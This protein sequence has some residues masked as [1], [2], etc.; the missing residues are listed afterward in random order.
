[1]KIPNFFLKI[2]DFFPLQHWLQECCKSPIM[3]KGTL[4]VLVDQIHHGN[5]KAASHFDIQPD[6][7]FLSFLFSPSS[8]VS[9]KLLDGAA[10]PEKSIFSCPTVDWLPAER[11]I[12]GRQG[13][14]SLMLCGRWHR[15]AALPS[16]PMALFKISAPRLAAVCG[17]L[18]PR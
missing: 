1:M 18:C 9:L 3:H 4:L 13:A 2:K 5:Q 12:V 10:P 15:L 14:E 6:A 8:S 17:S 7:S 16:G 11:G